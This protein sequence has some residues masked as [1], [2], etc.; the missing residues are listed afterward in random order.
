MIHRLRRDERGA[1][2]TETAFVLPVVLV[3]ILCAFEFG[4]VYRNVQ[5]LHGAS[6][7][8][9][10]LVSNMGTNERADQ[11]AVIQ[12]MES[13]DDLQPGTIK[14]IVIFKAEADGSF[15][16]P[17]CETV[18]H[19]NE[20]NTYG[21]AEIADR[22]NDAMWACGGT[23]HD[24]KFCPSVDRSD[25]QGAGVTRIGVRVYADHDYITDLL[26]FAPSEL[27]STT[28]MNIEPRN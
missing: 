7:S 23:A 11:Q 22:A 10:R 5:T 4:L 6:R 3:I 24:K 16:H 17:N 19:P 27:K 13:A 9:A 21:P 8:G 26:P 20:C 15:P 1:A 12:I 2:I 18:G 25:S 14:K 28:V